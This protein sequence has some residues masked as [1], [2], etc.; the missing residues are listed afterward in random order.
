MNVTD[1]LSAV[2]ILAAILTFFFGLVR[3]GMDDALKLIPDAPEKKKA[4][5]RQRH[6][7]NLILWLQGVPVFIGSVV[8]WYI[9]FPQTVDI[10]RTSTLDYWHFD[11]AH[12][13]F[14]LLETCLSVLVLLTS[15]YVYR[16]WRKLREFGKAE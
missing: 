3:K 4:R 9:C 2:S 7:L 11:V 10:L 8:L 5:Q 14:V 15:S 13:L 6:D 1:A 12:S 16:L